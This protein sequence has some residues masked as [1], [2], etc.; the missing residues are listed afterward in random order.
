[1]STRR[2]ARIALAITVSLGVSA[3]VAFGLWSA[4]PQEST[5]VTPAQDFTLPVSDGTSDQYERD[6]QRAITS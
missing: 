1:M 2:A 3:L 4:R 5:D 6:F